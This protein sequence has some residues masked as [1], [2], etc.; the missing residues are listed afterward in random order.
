MDSNWN[1]GNKSFTGTA[2]ISDSAAGTAYANSTSKAL[3][4]TAN[5]NL[6][7]LKGFSSILCKMGFRKKF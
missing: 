4:T 7:G 1:L 3:T 6:S 2:S 5:I